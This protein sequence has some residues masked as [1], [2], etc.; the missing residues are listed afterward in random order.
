M[1]WWCGSGDGWGEMEIKAY[2]VELNN[3]PLIHSFL[4]ANS[5]D[6]AIQALS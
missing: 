1:G 6:K 5:R 3:I 4:T 2:Q